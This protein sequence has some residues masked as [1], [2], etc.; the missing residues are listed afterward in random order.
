MH[1]SLKPVF[2][3]SLIFFSACKNQK[4]EAATTNSV[5][6]EYPAVK[7]VDTVDN[8]FG[9]LVKDPYRWLENE[10]DTAVA[11]WVSA[12]N[13]VTFGY[14]E[15]IPYRN[16]IKNRLTEL[17]NYPKMTTPYR[18]GKYYF[19][20]KNTGLQNQYVTYF[21]EGMEGEEKIFLDLNTLST[22]GTVSASI[23]G[24]SNDKKYATISISKAGSDWNDMY[25]RELATN[26]ELSDK[27]EWTKFSGAAWYKDGFF[28][29]AYD[30]PGD[31]K[32]YTGASENCKIYYHK[33]GTA[34]SSDKLIYQDKANP[35]RYFGAQ[36]TQDEK[37]IFIYESEGTSGSGILWKNLADEKAEFKQLF[38]G[39]EWE[40][41]VLDNE[42]DKL[43]VL[44]NYKAPNYKVVLVDPKNPE[45]ENWKELISEKPELLQSVTLA[46]NKLFSFYLKNVS[47]RVYQHK[48]SGEMEREVILP[49]LGTVSGFYGE[50]ED[51]ELYYSFVSFTVPADI[52]KYEI[53]SG[54]SSMFKKSEIKFDAS[55]YETIQVF[56]PSKDGTKIPMFLTYKKGLKLDGNNPC[57]LYAYG[58]FNIARI[59]EFNP[60][61]VA[62]LE[63]GFVYAVANL[64]GGSEYG[65][66]WHKAG[67]LDKKQNVFDDFIAA[68]EYLIKEKYTSSKKLAVYGRSNGG[69]LIGAV[70]TQRPDLFAVALPRV[71]VLDMLRYHKFTIGWAWAVEYGSA[72][73]PEQFE[74][75]LKYSPLHNVKPGT[76]YPATL[77]TTGDHD[78]RVVPAHSFKF[79]SAL[80]AA[81][82]GDNPVLI[83]VDVQ[84]GHGAGKP[85]SKV[86]DEEADVISFTMWNMGIKQMHSG[87]KP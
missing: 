67:M 19:F 36:T 34:Q 77:I 17:N 81:H 55:K 9:T 8:Y 82:T 3:A 66:E 76:K 53:G 52:Y 78:D 80:Q 20:G 59:P 1:I 41:S 16:Q 11:Q 22:D 48:R 79:V 70:M 74:Y 85:L 75:L 69:L 4:N 25:I 38:K 32:T 10:N 63:Q 49:G 64:R 58:G 86:M 71:G 23:A 2:I 6:I 13:A 35:R 51:T 47:S 57:F 50:K 30:K 5:S 45:P 26:K 44:T 27:I 33:I 56:Y 87:D 14:L 28:Y 72:E 46:G 73:N 7:T 15:N 54:T 29:S 68:A 42:G 84:A 31:N 43:I 61:N 24:F 83:R 39:F 62:M 18:V 40:Y 65:E 12:Q 21:K 37:F 60:A